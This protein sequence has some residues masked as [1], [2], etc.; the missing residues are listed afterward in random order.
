M[1]AVPDLIAML[2]LAILSADILAEPSPPQPSRLS[3]GGRAY[4]SALVLIFFTILMM[5]ATLRVRYQRV[6]F[7]CLIGA[8][9]FG[10]AV[11]KDAC[12]SFME[13]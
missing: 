13:I 12:K 10:G 7:V 3:R 2:V 8:F 11:R 5:Y 4:I 6:I 1:Q 9:C